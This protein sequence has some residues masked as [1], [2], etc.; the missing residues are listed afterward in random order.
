MIQMLKL[1]S[2][3]FVLQVNK[4]ISDKSAFWSLSSF[5]CGKNALAMQRGSSEVVANEEIYNE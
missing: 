2:T 1:L 5:E 3:N 4:Q